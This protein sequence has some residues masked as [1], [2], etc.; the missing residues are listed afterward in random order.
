ML[1]GRGVADQL[2]KESGLR[3]RSSHVD[4]L[5]AAIASGNWGEA[6]DIIDTIDFVTKTPEEIKAMVIE[7]KYLE[8]IKRCQ[9]QP[10]LLCLRKELKGKCRPERYHL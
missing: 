1:H 8:M 4:D 9:V 10:A 7:C 3:I 6:S 2:E 5:F